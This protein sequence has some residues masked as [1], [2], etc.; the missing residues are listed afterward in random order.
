MSS[1]S[2]GVTSGT[3]LVNSGDTTGELVLKTNGS[4][5]AV[6]LDTSQKA[7]FAGDIAVN[8][9]LTAPSNLVLKTNGNTTALT[10]TSAQNA[11]FANAVGVTTAAISNTKFYVV[12]G[13]AGGVTATT[14]TVDCSANNYFTFTAVGTNSWT[15]SNVPA[16]SSYGFVLQLTN[17]GTATQTWPA[18][19]RWPGGTAP[20][21]TASG[22]DLL[23]FTTSNGGTTWRGASL[24]NYSA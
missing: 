19:V 17:G 16:S 3:A 6:T 14:N 11:T 5:T 1:I 12:G 4:T 8:G 7:T 22:V 9:S 2:A 13:Q 20:T 18:S 10:L 23:I 15:F 24:L 21:L